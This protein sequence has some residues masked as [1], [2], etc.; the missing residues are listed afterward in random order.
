MNATE[1]ANQAASTAQRALELAEQARRAAEA[2][3]P[4]AAAAEPP[5]EADLVL[6]D[7][8]SIT[9]VH[10][11]LCTQRLQM[12]TQATRPPLRLNVHSLHSLTYPSLVY[13]EG[14]HSRCIT[15]CPSGTHST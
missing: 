14:Y 7:C 5:V 12:T 2:V 11:P 9:Q 6:C 4:V 1:L 13:S 10:L 8:G 3:A 15:R